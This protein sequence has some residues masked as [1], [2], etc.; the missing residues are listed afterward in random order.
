MD[1]LGL[2]HWEPLRKLLG[3][4]EVLG[5][6]GAALL[7]QHSLDGAVAGAAVWDRADTFDKLD[8]FPCDQLLGV[9]S[10]AEAI[11]CDRERFAQLLDECVLVS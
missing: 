6:A 9:A 11:V 3:K 8:D 5:G 4:V 7:A 2:G 10:G 1:D